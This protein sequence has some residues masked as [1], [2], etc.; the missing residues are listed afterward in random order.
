MTEEIF[1][2]RY[3]FVY[4]H[5]HYMRL[6][7]DDGEGLAA[8]ALSNLQLKMLEANTI[9]NILPLEI[10]EVDNRINLLYSLSAKRMLAQVLKVEELSKCHFAKLMYAIVCAIDESKNYMLHETGF[11]LKDNFIFI[12]NGWSDVFLTYVPMDQSTDEWRVHNA[13]LDLM[14]QIGSKLN[15][16]T[17]RDVE[18]SLETM[19]SIQS[20][21]DFKIKLLKLMDQQSTVQEGLPKPIWKQNAVIK[22]LNLINSADESPIH[23]P[24]L[25]AKQEIVSAQSVVFTPT[26]QR[27]QIIVLIGVILVMALLWQHYVSSPSTS[28][29]HLSAG[30]TMLLADV[31]FVLKFLGRPRYNRVGEKHVP[32]FSDHTE[33]HS[34]NKREA[35]TVSKVEPPDIQSHYQNLHMHTTLLQNNARNA[36]VFLGNQNLKIKPE[37]PRLER[38]HQGVQTS[39]PTSVP[40]LC[41]HFTIGRG[42]DNLKAD[43]VLE[44]AGVS[45][46]HAEIT[47]CDQGYALKDT[48]STNGTSLNG[49]A[50]VTYQSYLLKDGDEIQIVCQTIIFRY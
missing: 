7:K 30:I 15:D 9:P 37:G 44:E 33:K 6:Y 8:D 16:E 21:Q 46:I 26:T 11:V 35:S 18:A 41:D 13:I 24:V 5:G 12:G 43:Y 27:T 22:P 4:Q 34:G 2:L 1:G 49:E 3:E 23:S 40:I 14:R 31:W 47:K 45:R 10:Q 28:T 36:T 39:V 17:R 48:G 20:L 42:D 29:L 32:F 19:A 50:L 38:Q 25:D